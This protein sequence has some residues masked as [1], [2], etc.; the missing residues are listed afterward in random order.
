ML[1]GVGMSLAKRYWNCTCPG[2]TAATSI[3]R[4]ST[5]SECDRSIVK[6]TWCRA[7]HTWFREGKRSSFFPKTDRLT[8]SAASHLGTWFIKFIMGE[9][10]HG[11]FF[12]F[13]QD[14][15]ICQVVF[16]GQRLLTYCTYPIPTTPQEGIR[17]KWVRRKVQDPKS[18]EKNWHQDVASLTCMLQIRWIPCTNQPCSSFS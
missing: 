4:M 1:A 15:H 6:E 5:A 12:K 10:C 17:E 2:V 18:W 14:M 3:H 16:R 8:Q 11:S 7:T 13:F 9:S